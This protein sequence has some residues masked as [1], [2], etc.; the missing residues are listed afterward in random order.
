M[1]R[2]LWRKFQ[3]VLKN[4]LLQG[5]APEQ[6]SLTITLGIL[7]GIIPVIGVT[8]ILLALIAIRLKLN[9]VVIQLTNFAVYPLQLLLLIPF[10]KLGQIIFQGPVLVT[11]FQQIQQAL[12]SAPLKIFYYFW[13]LTI[14]G[15]V[16]WLVFSVPTGFILYYVILIPMR[17]FAKK[18]TPIIYKKSL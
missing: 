13:R 8:T 9:M 6:V 7:F 17:K 16:V 14:Q 10:F 12:T 18:N 5:T 2:R 15:T 1:I 11:G 3:Q 4:S